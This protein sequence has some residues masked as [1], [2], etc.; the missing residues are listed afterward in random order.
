MTELILYHS[1]TLRSLNRISLFT[2]VREVEYELLVNDTYTVDG[3]YYPFYFYF[4]F[5]FE[6]KNRYG[7]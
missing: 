1:G 5:P 7:L 2:E 4:V 3:F 6:R